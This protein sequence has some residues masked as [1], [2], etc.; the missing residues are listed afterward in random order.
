MVPEPPGTNCALGGVKLQV[1]TG[2]PSYVCN[3]APAGTALPTV[4][5][6]G[7]TG[8][9]YTEATVNGEVV[10]DGGEII[11][12]RGVVVSTTAGPTL[13]DTVFLSGAGA[14]SF[15][16]NCT[17]L[18]PATAYHARAFATNALGTA[19]GAEIT[20]TTL[21]LTTPAVATTPAANVTDTTVLSGGNVTDDG[22]TAVLS[23]G[24]CWATAPSPT[25]SDTCIAEGSGTGSYLALITALTPG[26]AYHARAYATNAQ[27]TGYGDDQPFTTVQLPLATVTTAAISAVSYT[28]ATG[29]GTVVSDHG[30]PVTSRGI[31]WSTTAAPTT[32]GTCFSEAGGLGTFTGALTGLTAGTAYHVRAF[33]VNGGGTSYG[34]EVTFTT[35]PVS[36]P[37]LV[38]KAVTGISS[39]IA[40][41]GGVIATDGGSPITAKGVCWGVNPAPTIAGSHSTDGAGAASFNSTMTGLTPLTAYHVR[42][43]ATNA[44]GTSYGDDLTFTTTDLLLPGPTVPIVGT[45]TPAIATSSTASSGGYVSG[46]GGS[47]VTARGVC[48]GT[49]QNPTLADS[50]STDGGTG[51]G[52]FSSTVT[53]LAGCGVVYYVRAYATNSTGTGY[54]NQA[55]VSTGLLPT[56]TTAPVTGIGFYDATSG[57]TVTDDGGCAIT[58]KGIA[59]WWNPAPLIGHAWTTDGAGGGTWA[60][61]ITGL[62]ANRTYYVRAYATNSVGTTYG[63]QL[64]FTTAEPSTPYIGQSYAGGTI[65]YLDGTGLHGLVAAP[66][67]IGWL[68]WGCAGTSIA[69]GTAVGTGASNTAA[70]VASCAE[71]TFAAKSA[72]ALVVGG[73]GDWFLPS[74]DEVSLMFTNLAAKGL[75][76]FSGYAYRTS[77]EINASDAW[78]VHFYRGDRWGERKQYDGPVRPAR[79]F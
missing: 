66:G 70:I 67:D 7:A 32:S 52:H 24:V 57:G 27:G 21:A 34:D 17:G 73:Y 15:P 14:G 63:D 72:D 29:G 54:G 13:H 31:C 35:L 46:D 11:F 53:G 6:L 4:A 37:V 64:T 59:W 36:A 1:G 56:V 62:Y 60:S 20:F 47:P 45:T 22:G 33:A 41:S 40:G 42:A 75:G 61:S 51:V 39:N 2:T 3:G 18:A 19:Y 38:T 65:F 78:I 48:W 50:C 26:T 12:A 23:R 55:T 77:S 58:Q 74:V 69:T 28:S 71:A 76:G 8:V 9:R 5:T 10:D 25:I 43:Y 16:A 44:L 68:P 30:S 79:A 49:A